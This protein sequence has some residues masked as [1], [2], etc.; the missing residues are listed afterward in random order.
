LYFAE[1]KVRKSNG[2]LDR[3]GLAFVLIDLPSDCLN[4]FVKNF[5]NI[6]RLILD[7]SLDSSSALVVDNNNFIEQYL[8]SDNRNAFGSRSYQ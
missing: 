3:D 5:N 2:V 6:L 8:N 1:F 7:N 4:P